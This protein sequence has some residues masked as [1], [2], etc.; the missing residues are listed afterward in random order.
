[1]FEDI[2]GKFG[3][4]D[5]PDNF[6]PIYTPKISPPLKLLLQKRSNCRLGQALR[7]PGG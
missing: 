3:T 1:V 2:L 4:P 5:V 6:R 7:V